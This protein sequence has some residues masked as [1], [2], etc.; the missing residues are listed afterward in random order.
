V[1]SDRALSIV[2][3]IMNWHAIR[4]DSYASPI[5]PGMARTSAKDRARDRIL[6]DSEL[7]AIWSAAEAHPSPFSS[8]VMLL[9]LVGARRCE[10]ARMQWSELSADGT[11]WTL[12]ARRH[13]LKTDL[14]RPLSGAARQ[15]LA[16]LPRIGEFVF[17]SNG[18]Q[19]IGAFSK[20]KRRLDEATG[21]TGWTLHD[22]R[23]T[24]RSLLSRCG[25]RPDIAERAL[26]HVVGS[27]VARVYDR[28]GYDRELAEAYEQ[29]AALIERIVH[30]EANVVQLTR[31]AC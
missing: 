18:H 27:S 30:P 31:P 12:P 2:R 14:T 8:L 1:A 7:K 22:L 23:R 28:Y 5:V 24:C 26:G 19:P 4:D 3:T 11:S 13:K 29:L 25:V 21:V 20:G 10:A 6:D 15:V 16:G 17:T 9:L